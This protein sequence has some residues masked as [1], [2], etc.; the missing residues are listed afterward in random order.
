M[1]VMLKL[2]IFI[3]MGIICCPAL[4]SAQSLY[5]DFVKPP[6]DFKRGFYM[7]TDSGII[8]FIGT[9]GLVKNPGYNL[10]FFT[11]YDI[12]RFVSVEGRFRAAINSTDPLVQPLNGGMYSFIGNGLFRFSYPIHRVFPFLDFGAGI[13]VTDPEYEFGI[14]KKYDIEIG[15]GAEYY[16][17]QRHF[18]MVFR[19]SYI[20]VAGI[21]PDAL[22]FNL[23]LKYTF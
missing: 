5:G 1:K 19:S 16:T 14:S 11:G 12:S 7:G 13:F 17:Y 9:K 2:K 21:L 22:V 18:S 6:T 20:Y 23:A 8:F 4:L 3:I 10:A 15:Y